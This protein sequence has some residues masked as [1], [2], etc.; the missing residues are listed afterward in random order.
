MHGE[1]CTVACLAS[2]AAEFYSHFESSHWTLERRRTGSL[3][4]ARKSLFLLDSRLVSIEFRSS[5]QYRK[6][7]QDVVESAYCDEGERNVWIGLVE[8]GLEA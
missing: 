1:Y 8:I 5:M 7:V 2:H 4:A 3:S 6:Y